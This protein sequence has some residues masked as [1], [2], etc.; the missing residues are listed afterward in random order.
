MKEL[1]QQILVLLDQ[2]QLPLD[3][4]ELAAKT[5]SLQTEMNLA[6]DSLQMDELVAR[7]D[8]FGAAY[9]VITV[10]GR[11][12]ARNQTHE[13]ARQDV[14]APTLPIAIATPVPTQAPA[15]AAAPAETRVPLKRAPRRSVESWAQDCLKL[16]RGGP[17]TAS[18][19]ELHLGITSGSTSMRML[20]LLSN[21]G[22]ISKASRNAPWTLTE[23][24]I[25]GGGQH[26][27]AV[28]P[29]QARRRWSC[30]TQKPNPRPACAGP[31]AHRHGGAATAGAAPGAAHRPPPGAEVRG[32]GASR[33][34]GRSDYRRRAR[35]NPQRPAAGELT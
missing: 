19:L 8:R 28:H 6:L 25:S 15:T 22:L 34:P 31:R 27:R 10:A 24:G 29:H 18:Q 12:H 9:Y 17:L 7:S 1:K 30:T 11:R 21:Q 32:A 2:A 16:L 13:P 35:G 5:T 20:N 23:A 26:R 14:P 33:A 3:S 4:R